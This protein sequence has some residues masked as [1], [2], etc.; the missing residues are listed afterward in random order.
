[1]NWVQIN[2]QVNEDFFMHSLLETKLLPIP[3]QLRTYLQR[4]LVVP[5]R[6]DV[7]DVSV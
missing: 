6:I 1:M 4:I 2:I 7:T 3:F 5:L